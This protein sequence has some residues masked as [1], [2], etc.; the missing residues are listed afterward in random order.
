MLDGEGELFEGTVLARLIALLPDGSAL[1]VGNSLPV[2][3]LDTFV[4]GAATTL[5][6]FGNRGANGIDGVLSTAL[7]AAAARTGPT[8]LVVGDLSFLHDLG[9]L[10]IT[11]RHRL[12]LLV[13]VINNDG[14]GLF[15]FLPQAAL[16][17]TFETLFGTPHGLELGGA[18]TMC[19]GRHVVA[20]TRGEL[21][22]AID[23]WLARPALT[24]I[25][26]PSDRA[27]TR[28]LHARLIAAACA[29]V[30]GRSGD[31]VAR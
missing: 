16:G 28:A 2:R 27:A 5:A 12:P 24:V 21:G 17:A 14:G 10:Q 20:R 31:A 29:A 19:G 3:A 26:V 23:A 13:V 4:G 6:V 8:A 30:H 15:S 11:A 9:G 1:H 25:E 22:V 18:V 7:G